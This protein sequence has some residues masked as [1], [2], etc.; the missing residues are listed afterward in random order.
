MRKVN[1]VWCIDHSIQLTV[2]KVL[3]FIKEPTEQL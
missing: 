3:T 2:L 1:H